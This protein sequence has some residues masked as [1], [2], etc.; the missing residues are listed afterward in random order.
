MPLSLP[1]TLS[2]EIKYL[3]CINS[4]ISIII[5]FNLLQHNLIK[6]LILVIIERIILILL[7][8]IENMT[9][10]YTRQTVTREQWSIKRE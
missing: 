7:I 1:L 4:H 8:V 10:V 9:K 2:C 5:P 3:W 6:R